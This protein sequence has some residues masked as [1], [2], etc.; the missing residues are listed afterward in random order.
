MIKHIF[1]IHFLLLFLACNSSAPVVKE[2]SKS[3]SDT[4][5]VTGNSKKEPLITSEEVKTIVSYLASDEL[6]GRATGSEGI[7]K[8]A[9]YIETYFKDNGVTPY[10]D[11]YRDFFKVKDLDAFNVVG[12]VEGN[13]KDLKNEYI[14]IGA[15]Y[16]H[17]GK[18]K[19][20]DGDIIANGANDN[21]AGT[22]VVMTMAKYFAKHKQNKRS[23]I[24]ALFSAEESGLLGSK[25]LADKLKSEGLKLY[26]MLNFEMI[27]VPLQGKSYTA[28]VTGYEK[29]NLAE[30][31]NEYASANLAGFLP[32]A[33]EYQ[34]FFRSDNYPFYQAFNV[35]C[36][37]FSTFDFTNF[38]YYHHVDDEADKLDF[39]HMSNFINAF[40]PG[41]K[42]I[43]NSESGSIKLKE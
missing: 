39:Q 5:T 34:L 9:S 36:Q 6:Q 32:Q 2:T 7:D 3:S 42:G 23:I 1:I 26:T 40:I 8:A 37:T 24:F 35:P 29:T 31:I 41:V 27:G 20:V 11:D 15:H 14:V 4:G 30:K 10:F 43:V 13:D 28:Y 22:A 21:A 38:N 18:G 25:H 12:V 33:K 16:D 19:A 17:I